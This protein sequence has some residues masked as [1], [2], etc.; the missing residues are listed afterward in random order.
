MS[1]R[2][3]R[4]RGF[5]LVQT[6]V[7]ILVIV[8]GIALL[9]PTLG[10]RRINRSQLKDSMHIRAV[11]QALWIWSANNKGRYPLPSVVDVDNATIA[12]PAETKDTTAHLLSMLVYNGTITPELLVSPSEASSSVVVASG[13]SYQSPPAAADRAAALWDPSFRGTPIDRLLP[14]ATDA[15]GNQS[16]AFVIPLGRRREVYWRESSAEAGAPLVGNR[17]P[18][19][20]SE[21][22]APGSERWTLPPGPL[23]AESLTLRIHGGRTTWEGN[24]GLVGG[25]VVFRRSVTPEGVTY[26]HRSGALG[27]DNLFVNETDEAAGDAPGRLDRGLNA[28]LRPIAKLDSSGAATLWRD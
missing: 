21:D 7:L 10:H 26:A 2:P 14:G 25:G 5:T 18:T 8:V 28:Y 12:A 3:V 23:G 13:Y 1:L 24:V 22:A 27:R 17:G 4:A 20:A 6:F 16:Y 11:V 15:R 9:L 19:F